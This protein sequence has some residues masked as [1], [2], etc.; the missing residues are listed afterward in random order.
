M[1][2][3]LSNHIRWRR[4]GKGLEPQ[5]QPNCG[6]IGFITLENL[7]PKAQRRARVSSIG[8]LRRCPGQF[9]PKGRNPKVQPGVF[10][11]LAHTQQDEVFFN[12]I[13]RRERRPAAKD[14]VIAG[15]QAIKFTLPVARG[16]SIALAESESHALQS[17]LPN[18]EASYGSTSNASGE[19]AGNQRP[20]YPGLAISSNQRTSP[21][22]LDCL[23]DTL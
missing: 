6:F 4:Y 21:P 17:T 13:R 11:R 9:R 1:R 22:N 3:G 18:G 10:A 5:G 15:A 14:F 2:D 7:N 12:S 19:I 20:L 23:N 16:G 8:S